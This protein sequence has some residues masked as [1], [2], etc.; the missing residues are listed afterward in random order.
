MNRWGKKTIPSEFAPCEYIYALSCIKC[1]VP[2]MHHMCFGILDSSEEQALAIEDGIMARLRVKPVQNKHNERAIMAL[3]EIM[4]NPSCGKSA[5]LM[6]PVGTGKTFLAQHT[7]KAIISKHRLKCLYVQEHTILNAW[8]F[9]QQKDKQATAAWAGR[10]LGM[11]RSAEYLLIDDFGASRRTS[12]GALDALE[13]L[14]MVRYDAARPVIITTNLKP[15]DIETRRGSRVWSRL[16]GMAKE[17][18][19]EINGGDY[20]QDV[21]WEVN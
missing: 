13:E 10:L 18:V 4:M 12:D 6:G 2:R 7:L 16:K 5:I 20:R 17:N 3:R 9:S 21:K 19:I 1:D 15:E 8:R 11:A 14:V